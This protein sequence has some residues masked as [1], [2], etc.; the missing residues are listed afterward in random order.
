M[1]LASWVARL[2]NGAEKELKPTSST[3][4]LLVFYS[5]H[6]LKFLSYNC[7]K[8]LYFEDFRDPRQ[9][10]CVENQAQYDHFPR[11]ALLQNEIDLKSVYFQN[12]SEMKRL[13]AAPKD[14]KA[15]F[16]CPKCFTTF[17]SFAPASSSA[18]RDLDHNENLQPW[19]RRRLQE[20]PANLESLDSLEI[21]SLKRQNITSFH[22]VG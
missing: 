10:P 8:G 13:K 19:P 14:F 17:H 16:S 12:K 4:G 6:S 18:I 11:V 15:L 3:L 9:S 22:S 1:Q 2:Q 5:T 20:I 21:L 7:P